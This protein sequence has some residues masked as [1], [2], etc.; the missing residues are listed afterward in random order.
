MCTCPWESECATRNTCVGPAP[1]LKPLQTLLHFCIITSWENISFYLLCSDSV[2]QQRRPPSH[3]A[4]MISCCASKVLL[5]GRCL[6]CLRLTLTCL[7]G[8]PM[9][10]ALNAGVN[11][12]MTQWDAIARNTF[13]GG[14]ASVRVLVPPW[15][16]FNWLPSAWVHTK[17]TGRFQFGCNV[18]N[19]AGLAFSQRLAADVWGNTVFLSGFHW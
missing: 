14:M 17:H 10:T 2:Q 16:W 6:R 7:S 9:W 19:I 18:N 12:P 15:R 11:A 13:T 4:M 8:D 3:W 1:A 5:Q